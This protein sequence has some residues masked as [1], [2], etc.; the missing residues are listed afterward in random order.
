[1]Q[2]SSRGSLGRA[3]LFL[4]AGMATG[5]QT[6]QLIMWG[7]WGKPAVPLERVALFGALVLLCGGLVTIGNRCWGIAAAAL[8]CVLLWVFY[9]PATWNTLAELY[10][11]PDVSD[12]ELTIVFVPVALL[13]ASTLVV[14]GSVPTS[15]TRRSLTPSP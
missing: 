2:A 5:W 15:P 1:M 11:R 14:L 7:V 9:G 4:L 6:L 13:A 12:T 10:T 8:G 3:A